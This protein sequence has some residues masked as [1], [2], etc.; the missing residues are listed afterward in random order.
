MN[1]LASTVLSVSD[2]AE[3]AGY[4]SVH[5][6]M[7]HMK[8]A[9]GRNCSEFRVDCWQPNSRASSLVRWTVH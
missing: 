9:T 5:S 7:T 2:V 1:L 4:V 8:I 3:K 6:L